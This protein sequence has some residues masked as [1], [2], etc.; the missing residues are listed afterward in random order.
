MRYILKVSYNGKNYS[1]FQI[2]DNVDTIQEEIEKA[3]SIAFNCEINIVSSGRTD[4]GVSA[5]E[6]I[7]HFDMEEYSNIEKKIGHINSLLPKDIRVLSIE[8]TSDDFHARYS[9]KKKTYE[10]YFYVDLK[11]KKKKS[12]GQNQIL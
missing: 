10:Y 5:L 1:G 4:S 2:Q 12:T 8:E 9:A 6:Q 3:M 7:C 11:L